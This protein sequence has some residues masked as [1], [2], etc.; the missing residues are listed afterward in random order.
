MF[1]V[2]YGEENNSSCNV[3]EGSAIVLI[4][5]TEAECDAMYERIKGRA[6]VGGLANYGRR[7]VDLTERPGV[8]VLAENYYAVNLEAVDHEGTP[9]FP[10]QYTNIKPLAE[11]P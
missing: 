3:H 11:V 7:V 6:G 1:M 5:K 2:M 8:A 4:A 10:D 9:I